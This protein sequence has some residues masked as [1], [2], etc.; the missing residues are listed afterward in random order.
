L[1]FTGEVTISDLA[2]VIR[3]EGA[4]VKKQAG[5]GASSRPA[6]R[7]GLEVPPLG[8]LPINVEGLGTESEERRLAALSAQMN[9]S[10][11]LEAAASELPG[12]SEAGSSMEAVW[13]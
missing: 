11:V 6:A 10:N 1:Y 4:G 12:F 3:S 2:L 5:D 9:E 8:I 7:F 13:N